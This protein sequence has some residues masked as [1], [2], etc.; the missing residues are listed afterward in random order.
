MK[1]LFASLALVAT[2][3]AAASV[4]VAAPASAAGIYV[5]V[6][7]THHYNHHY[8]H[9]GYAHPTIVV[10]TGP[11]YWHGRHWHNRYWCDRWHHRW[12]YR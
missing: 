4:P 11:Y 8:Y 2:L 6:G 10:G 9:R 7:P 12:C 3:G 1:K 5:H